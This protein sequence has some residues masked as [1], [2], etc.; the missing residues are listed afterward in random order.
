MRAVELGPS[1][2]LPMG[3]GNAVPGGEKM[4]NRACGTH[5]GGPSGGFGG[6]LYGATKRMRGVPHLVS[7]THADGPTGG[8]G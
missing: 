8:F 3:P 1:G 7:G 5:A 6:A 2:E 4:Q